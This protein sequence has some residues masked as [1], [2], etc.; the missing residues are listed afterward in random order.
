[1]E[2]AELAR[3]AASTKV[4]ALEVTICVLQSERENDLETDELREERLK[5]RIGEL[6]KD[7]SNVGD[8][9]TVLE[10][11]KVRL[12]A[13]PSSSHISAF[14]YILRDLYEKW[15][16]AEAQLG[17]FKDLMMAGK[18]QEANFE[19]T[20]N[21]ARSARI[22]YG[23]DPATPQADDD[24]GDV[25]GIEQ[26]AWYEDEYLNNDGDGRETGGDGTTGLGSEY[27][28]FFLLFVTFV[29]TFSG[30]FFSICKKH[31]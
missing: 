4:E 10:A 30:V 23:Y 1:M 6:E 15:I 7:A 2:K 16:H 17:I 24:E 22:A 25:K 12:T 8:Q 29:H 3:L 18:V 14:P 21:K 9:V 31:I 27:L 26:D 28:F 11:E 19:D 20:R 5:E 13:Q